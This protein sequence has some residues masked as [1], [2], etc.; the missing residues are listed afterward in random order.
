MYTGLVDH[1]AEILK[2]QRN[3]SLWSAANIIAAVMTSAGKSFTGEITPKEIF[4]QMTGGKPAIEEDS[5]DYDEGS[6]AELK[7]QRRERERAEMN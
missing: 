3:L 2:A 5:P 6:L 4:D 7:R 1:D